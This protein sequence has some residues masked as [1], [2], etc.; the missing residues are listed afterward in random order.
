M[1]D[2][3]VVTHDIDA[4]SELAGDRGTAGQFLLLTGRASCIYMYRWPFA[5]FSRRFPEPNAPEDLPAR[6]F[7]STQLLSPL[8]ARSH[9]HYKLADTNTHFF[10]NPCRLR[11]RGG[12]LEWLVVINQY[13][14]RQ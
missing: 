5:P 1:L 10:V 2:L 12:D 6:E 3:L 13:V 8:V 9:R 4:W 11:Q 7:Q 14:L